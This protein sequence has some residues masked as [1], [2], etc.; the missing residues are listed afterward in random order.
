MNIVVQ[1][2]MMVC[3]ILLVF[4]IGFLIVKN[5]RNQRF[6]PRMPRFK[7]RVGEEIEQ[8][9]TTGEF[10]AGWL[11]S[12]RERCRKTKYLLALQ[13]VLEVKPYARDWFREV[14][15]SLLFEYRKKS[16]YEQAYYAYVV[17]A[18]GYERAR[19]SS[20]F[21]S[22]FLSFLKSGSLY[23]FSNTM[24]AV[25]EFGDL[26]I[27]M[28]AIDV[29]D[30][31]AGFYHKKL[32][33]DGLLSARVDKKELAAA[34]MEQYDRYSDFTKECILEYFRFAEVD[35]GDFCRR[36]ISLEPKGSQVRYT[37]IRY[38]LKYPDEKAKGM[39][40]D[41]LR[42][43]EEGGWV[44]EMLAIQGLG[45]WQEKEI[46]DLMKS[47]ITSENW[48]VRVNALEYLKNSGMD[49]QEIAEIIGLEDPYTNEALVYQYREDPVM[50]DYIGRLIE[51]QKNRS[52]EEE[53]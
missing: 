9:N 49:E 12:V 37:A 52:K 16:D 41:M 27:L 42:S 48:Y 8:K 51:E 53:N 50:S 28:N 29:V 17:S 38:F 22:E 3:V 19:I 25:Y 33:V 46:R 36:V 13:G 26:C 45:R 21:A 18:L 6:Y 2:Y 40:A 11:D 23:T 43:R 47:H 44:E 14:I 35:A 10:S 32:F 31:R 7:K 1:I 30:E 15:Y 34:L 39:F 20:Y 4:D 24:A 5:A